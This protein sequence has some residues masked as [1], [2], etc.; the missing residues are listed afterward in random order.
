M[1]AP[2]TPPAPAILQTSLLLLYY[3]ILYYYYYYYYIS[4]LIPFLREGDVDRA[5]RHFM[6]PGC[7]TR[8][9]LVTV[10]GSHHRG[11]SDRRAHPAPA[12][13]G[14]GAS[15]STAL[16]CLALRIDVVSWPFAPGEPPAGRKARHG[17]RAQAPGTGDRA[18]SSRFLRRHSGA[19]AKQQ[20]QSPP[21]AG[22]TRPQRGA[23]A[24]GTGRAGKGPGACGAIVPLAR[25][26]YHWRTKI[27]IGAQEF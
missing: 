19:R 8:E 14:P 2:R 4:I 26:R 1:A 23:E 5:Q 15:Y 21:P 22:V 27:I 12:G 17:S 18:P 9:I 3:I 7:G 16:R 10:T 6:G 20:G 25:S 13:P 11:P 24:V